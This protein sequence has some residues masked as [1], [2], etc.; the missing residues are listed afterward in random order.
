ML[1]LAGLIFWIGL[2][3]AFWTK[4]MTAPV[5]AIIPQ[6]LEA[7]NLN[8]G[9]PMTSQINDEV[10]PDTDTTPKPAPPA[11]STKGANR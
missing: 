7:E 5:N 1:P 4:R 2:G 9:L 6:K 3:S 10:A 11:D 8:S